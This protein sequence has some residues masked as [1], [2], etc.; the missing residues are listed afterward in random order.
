MNQQQDNP[1]PLQPTIEPHEALK[2]SSYDNVAG[3]LVAA[4]ILVGFAVSLLVIIWY[5][6]TL[7]VREMLVEVQAFDEPIDQGDGARGP[8]NDFEEPAVDE[9]EEEEQ[10]LDDLLEAVTDM[11]TT[12]QAVEGGKGDQSPSGKGR[13]GGGTGGKGRK[14][15]G[16]VFRYDSNKKEYAR[17]LDF[18]KIE[19]AAL[20]G[21]VNR[22]DYARGFSTTPSKRT[23]QPGDEKRRWQAWN[24]RSKQEVDRRLLSQA[25]VNTQGR[26]VLQFLPPPVEQML[27][28]LQR[29]KAG[30]RP[31]EQIKTTIFGLRK[32]GEGYEFYVIDQKY[33]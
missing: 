8:M 3:L 24:T 31:L 15:P 29:Q 16:W 26:S 30:N 9:L 20:G 27:L 22:I 33:R 19:L 7:M 17:Q 32:V 28:N 25:G 12:V 11:V 1:E 23:G 6:K 4:L 5:T 21:G 18:F 14:Q 13:G 10:D 2:V